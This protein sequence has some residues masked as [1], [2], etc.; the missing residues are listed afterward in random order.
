MHYNSSVP[1]LIDQDYPVVLLYNGIHHYTSTTVIS[2]VEKN[3]A[4]CKLLEN[5][6]DNMVQVSQNLF[7]V[8][9]KAK[10][11]FQ[12]IKTYVHEAK[13]TLEKDP[14]FSSFTVP[15][16]SNLLLLLLLTLVLLLPLLLEQK[17]LRSLN[18]C[19]TYVT[20]SFRGAM[21]CRTIH[22]QSM[23][24]DFL[25]QAVTKSHLHQRLLLNSTKLKSME[26]VVLKFIAA[27]KQDAHTH[28]TDRML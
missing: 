13:N 3:V 1:N 22:N 27:Q 26:K 16:A 12:Y 24:Q 23:G 20:K 7:G 2:V 15:A 17:W 9:D 18:M 4:Y 5:M 10:Q 14:T 25:A 19:V 21:S 28:Q 11:A 6:A 8:G